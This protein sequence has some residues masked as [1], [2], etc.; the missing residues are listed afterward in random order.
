MKTIKLFII[1]KVILPYHKSLMT[2]SLRFKLFKFYSYH[3]ELYEQ[4]DYMYGRYRI[5]KIKY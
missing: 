4:A 1:Q 3:R 5:L 2:L